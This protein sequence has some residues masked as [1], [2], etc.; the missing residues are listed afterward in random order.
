MAQLVHASACL[1]RRLPRGDAKPPSAP[2]AT[3]LLGRG[4]IGPALS[5]VPVRPPYPM[6]VVGAC[7]KLPLA[8]ACQHCD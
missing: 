8:Q 2:W 3:D 7:E 6:E 1:G 4:S 5:T